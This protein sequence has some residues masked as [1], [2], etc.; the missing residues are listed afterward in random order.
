MHPDL[1]NL[2]KMAL[3]DGIL[4]IKE[5]EILI[6]KAKSLNVD[7]DEF[8]MELEFLISQQNVKVQTAEKQDE[9]KQVENNI[10]R[11]Y[12]QDL[13]DKFH[14][15]DDEIANP[16]KEQKTTGDRVENT[17]NKTIDTLLGDNIV[18][19]GVDLVTGFFG[20]ETSSEKKERK[21]S[22]KEFHRISLLQNKKAS[23]ISTYPLSKE[24][25][26]LTEFGNLCA[27]NYKSLFNKYEKNGISEGENNLM[28]AYQSKAQQ[29]LNT[30]KSHKNLNENQ[31]Q[32][33]EIIDEIINPKSVAKKLWN[34]F[35]KK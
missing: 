6:R 29:I 17:V 10:K 3:S 1:E 13:I 14:A 33:I 22:E 24:F 2:V 27:T 20:G 25:D 34:K 4:T 35:L 32:Q 5:Q 16:K 15:I 8:E 19:T 12:L 30:L 28:L 18:G 26:E 7:I 23:V 21:A 9:I 11:S 31:L